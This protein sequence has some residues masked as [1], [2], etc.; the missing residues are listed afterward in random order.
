[1]SFREDAEAMLPAAIGEHQRNIA[2]RETAERNAHAEANRKDSD[3]KAKLNRARELGAE[4]VAYL[5]EKGV[6]SLPIV[7]REGSDT[8]IG[9]AW[10]YRRTDSLYDLAYVMSHDEILTDEGL[11][12]SA[13]IEGDRVVYARLLEGDVA[14]KILQSE[15]FKSDIV[16]LVATGS[17]VYGGMS[18]H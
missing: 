17:Y 8:Q 5:V 16:H 2:E 7:E 12:G 3:E 18:N 6:P 1:M 14:L 9:Q 13:R 4:V 11:P 10:H 15:Q